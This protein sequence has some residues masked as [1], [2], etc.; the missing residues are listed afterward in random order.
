MSMV[1]RYYSAVWKYFWFI[2]C[3]PGHVILWIMYF[4]PTEWGKGRNVT[5]GGRQMRAKHIFAPLNSLFLLIFVLFLSLS[6]PLIGVHH[7]IFLGLFFILFTLPFFPLVLFIY[8]LF[9]MESL[10]WLSMNLSVLLP[11]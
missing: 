9:D 8:F 6:V 11:F 7:A 1:W 10:N 5:M 3:I 2:W 4:Y